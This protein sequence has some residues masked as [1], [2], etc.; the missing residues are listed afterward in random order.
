MSKYNLPEIDLNKLHRYSITGRKSKVNT[1]LFSNI[2]RW[3]ETCKLSDLFPKILKGADIKE[4]AGKVVDSYQ[5]EKPVVFAIGGHVIKCGLSPIINDL[6]AKGIVTAV[7]MNGSGAIHDY[8]IALNGATSEDVGDSIKDGSFGMADETGRDMNSA[9]KDY[10]NDTTGLGE[11][12]GIFIDKNPLNFKDFSIIY[13]CF[14][15]NIPLTVHV[16]IGTDIIHIHPSSDG[17]IT[18]KGSYNDFKLFASVVAD[19]GDGGCFFNIGSSVILPEVFLKAITLTRNLGF[20]VNNFTTV[21]M[22]MIQHYRPNTNVVNR[23]T[24]TGGKGY[25]LTGHHEIMLPLLYSLIMER[26]P[27]LKKNSI[28]HNIK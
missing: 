27:S 26:L 2:E 8:E 12:L 23:P 25:S 9:F 20:N 7:A 16:A 28:H 19:M 24:Q 22:D 14:K 6:I 18:G 15:N 1:S 11:A 17:R 21:N 3:G 13:S 5:N 4:I 10:V